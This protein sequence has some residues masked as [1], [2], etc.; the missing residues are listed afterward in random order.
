LT[1]PVV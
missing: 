1:G